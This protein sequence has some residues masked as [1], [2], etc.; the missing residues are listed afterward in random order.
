[1][2]ENIL[3]VQVLGS[4]QK[5]KLGNIPIPVEED[6]N[7]KR[8]LKDLY[9]IFEKQGHLKFADWDNIPEHVACKIKNYLKTQHAHHINT[10]IY[11][12]NKGVDLYSDNVI[13]ID[14]NF[15]ESIEILI[16]VNIEGDIVFHLDLDYNWE[17]IRN[18]KLQW[19]LDIKE[20]CKY[21]NRKDIYKWFTNVLD[22]HVRNNYLISELSI[23]SEE[24]SDVLEW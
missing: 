12:D 2:W 19:F 7:C 18:W 5:V 3:K 1:M 16:D 13:T 24:Y 14:I 6:D 23:S 8:W 10:E 15:L 4:K 21:I 17:S 22:S 20:I 11:T 9:D